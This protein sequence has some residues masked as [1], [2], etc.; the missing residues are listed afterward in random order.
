MLG[1]HGGGGPDPLAIQA[2]HEMV[3]SLAGAFGLSTNWSDVLFSKFAV[4]PTEAQNV[5]DQLPEWLQS[6]VPEGVEA[7][8]LKRIPFALAA[9]DL[10]GPNMSMK[11]Y[12][13]PKAK[14]IATSTPAA[15]KV[16]EILRSLTPTFKPEAID[17]LEQ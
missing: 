8:D 12:V 17:M 7:I 10:I 14:E 2:A 13:N 4:T 5:M 1:P 3:A 15:E 6:F 11:L 9:F 16:W